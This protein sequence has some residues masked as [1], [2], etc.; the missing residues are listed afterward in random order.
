VADA[1]PASFDGWYC[2]GLFKFVK[3]RR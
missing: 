1:D 2:A 3:P